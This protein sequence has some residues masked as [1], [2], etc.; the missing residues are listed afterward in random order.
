MLKRFAKK[1]HY[2][3]QG[4]TLIELLIVIAILGILAAV[5]IPQVTKFIESGK[6][7]A[8]NTELGMINTAVGAGM[9]DAQVSTVSGSGSSVL[10]PTTD[11][12]IALAADSATG[13]NVWIGDYIQGCTNYAVGTGWAKVAIQG[14]YSIT[15]AG[16]VSGVSYPGGPIWDTTNLEWK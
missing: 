2:G 7:S 10:D 6:V 1:F 8:A 12:P 13:V 11:C 5:A 4:F 15:S 16:I 14:T 3:E 9:A